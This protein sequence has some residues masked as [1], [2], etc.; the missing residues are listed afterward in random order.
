MK[1]R[2]PVMIDGIVHRVI[3]AENKEF[4]GRTACRLFFTLNKQSRSVV[5]KV[6][7]SIYGV[8]IDC[9]TCLVRSDSV[10]GLAP[11]LPKGLPT[12]PT[13]INGIT[14][15]VFYEE[16]TRNAGLTLC[17]IRFTQIGKPWPEGHAEAEPAA[18]PV[19][20]P[21]CLRGGAR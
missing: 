21:V 7:V 17:D 1:R 2:R 9:M 13:Q 16:N 19:D 14:H 20:C 15:A 11:P 4:M 12:E 3:D 18:G 6:G 10:G 5:A 8:S